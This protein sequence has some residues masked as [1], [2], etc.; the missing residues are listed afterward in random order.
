M[1]CR[2]NRGQD[3]TNFISTLLYLSSLPRILRRYIVKMICP[4]LNHAGFFDLC[5]IM[6]WGD[7]N[8]QNW[9]LIAQMN[10]DKIGV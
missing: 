1:F 3:L 5:P 7:Y 4:V 6:I 8:L 9:T 2:I 10:T